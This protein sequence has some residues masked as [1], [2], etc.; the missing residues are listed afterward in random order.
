[1]EKEKKNIITVIYPNI[2]QTVLRGMISKYPDYDSLST[3]II[4]NSK[5][6]GF[7]NVRISKND[8]F[9][10]KIMDNLIPGLESIWDSNTYEYFC[11]KVKQNN[12]EKVKLM[13]EKVDKY[14]QW[15]PVQFTKILK[16]SLVSTWNSTKKE[17]EEQLT[18]HYLNEGKRMFIMEMKEKNESMREQLLREIHANVICNNCLSTSF[19]GERY[20]CSECDNFNLCHYC[21]NCK[22]NTRFP[23][24][25][26]HFFIKLPTPIILDIQ[27]YNSIFA[28]NKKL[29]R[30][31]NNEPFEIK[32]NIINNGE[33]D[34]QECFISPI[35]FGNNY[36]GCLKKTIVSNCK[37]GD[38]IELDVLIK[39]E[40]DENEEDD[41]TEYEG[42]FRLMTQEGIPFGDILYIKLLMEEE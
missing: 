36:L 11:N 33:N 7:E 9:I 4:E 5:K 10:L 38:K 19:Q 13:I 15:N 31:K 29:L 39:F 1:M 20:I 28:P 40:D 12:I 27:K 3:K 34:L 24:N 17:I 21:Y 30:K 35:R 8:K 2:E 32:V 42:Y 25:P 14:P 16:N 26:Q 22:D 37:K 23:H 18:D 41:I 6:K